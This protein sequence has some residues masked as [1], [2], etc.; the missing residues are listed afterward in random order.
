MEIRQLGAADAGA[1]D[2][3][4]QRHRDSSMFLRSNARR[5]GLEY[6]GERYQAEYTAAFEHDA[7]VGVVSHSW[8]GMLL[9]QAPEHV[10]TLAC[11]C[12][13]FSKRKVTG[14]S[15]PA[16]QTTRAV[17]ALALAD[18]P[19]A[20]HGNETLY[21]VSL[22]EIL[23]PE[24]LSSGVVVCREPHPA[25]HEA[26]HAWRYAYDLET[27]GAPDNEETRAR[28]REF[29]DAQLGERNAWIALHEGRPVSLSAFNATLP[30]MVQLGG[31]YTPPS[32]RGRGYA[33]AAVAASLL[34]ARERGAERAVLFTLNPSAIRC[35][36]AVGFRAIGSYSLRL[37][38]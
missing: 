12:V 33:R 20:L 18:A 29:L 7:M 1:L 26:L 11:A 16:E 37:L 21:A 10:E 34:A 2:A 23:I 25:E 24:A 17:R 31:I 4:L 15:G 13:A 19:M 6:R 35:Y 3:F 5:A 30:D 36:E 27:L 38:A 22:S 9:V 32:E 28:S 8:S 14:F